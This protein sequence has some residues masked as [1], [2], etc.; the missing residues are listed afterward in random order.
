GRT[1]GRHRWS[2]TG[3]VGRDVWPLIDG[4]ADQS[5]VSDGARTRRINF[6]D[7]RR[8]S[9]FLRNHLVGD[10]ATGWRHG[11]PRITW[12]RGCCSS[13]EWSKVAGLV[14]SRAESGALVEN[15]SEE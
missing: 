3:Q 2:R 12:L 7:L 14:S 8:G 5:G 13:D 4:V 1:K 15:R 10:A 6:R 9:E 11:D